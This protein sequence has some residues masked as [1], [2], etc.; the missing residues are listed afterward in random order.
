MEGGTHTSV[1]SGG[2]D[3]QQEG[4][5]GKPLR[6]NIENVKYQFPRNACGNGMDPPRAWLLGFFLLAEV[7]A[8]SL[9]CFKKYLLLPITFTQAFLFQEFL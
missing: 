8:L 5:Q 2:D 1:P 4:R 3:T 9:G 7:L 6:S